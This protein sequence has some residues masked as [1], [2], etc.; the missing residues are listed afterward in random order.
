MI[1]GLFALL[2]CILA[3]SLPLT[4]QDP[5]PPDLDGL[6]TALPTSLTPDINGK[7]VLLTP[8][9]EIKVRNGDRRP[10]ASPADRTFYLGEHLQESSAN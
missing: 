3:L 10:S 1:R 9:T 6:I 2:A 8:A 4:A 5:P 7:H